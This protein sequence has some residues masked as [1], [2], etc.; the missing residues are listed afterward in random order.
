M[1]SWVTN[2]KPTIQTVL[3]Q[4]SSN[5]DAASAVRIA[6]SRMKA[7]VARGV[8]AVA[9]VHEKAP[10]LKE[11]EGTGATGT[12]YPVNIELADRLLSFMQVTRSITQCKTSFKSMLVR[13]LLY[14][15]L[16]NLVF[17]HRIL[18]IHSA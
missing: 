12:H 4:S 10:E 11:Q 18:V 1:K 3:C 6:R 16:Q 9:L 5:S 2:A 13:I 15:S 7:V 8:A 17:Y 14:S